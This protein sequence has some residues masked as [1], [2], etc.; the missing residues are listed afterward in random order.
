MK[1]I[2]KKWKE[3]FVKMTDILEQNAFDEAINKH[4]I[5][6]VLFGSKMCMPCISLK[7]KVNLWQQAHPAITCIYVPIEEALALAASKQVFSAPTMQLYVYGKL[8]V[9]YSGTFS[10]EEVCKQVIRYQTLIK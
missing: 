1:R 10:F 9:K 6:L 5:V 2:A 7:E 3:V 8:T 4:E